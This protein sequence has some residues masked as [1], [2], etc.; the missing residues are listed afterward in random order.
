MDKLISTVT[1]KE[2]WRKAFLP[3]LDLRKNAG[4]TIDNFGGRPLAG[5]IV[6]RSI[7]GTD[8]EQR[9]NYQY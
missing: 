3:S 1:I 4:S 9:P 6:G 7:E 2:G 8:A 5:Q